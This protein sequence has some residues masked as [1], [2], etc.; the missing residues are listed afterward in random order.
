MSEKNVAIV[1]AGGIGE[2]MK[3]SVPKQ[4]INLAGKPVILHTLEPFEKSDLIS[5]IIVVCHEDSI[6][7]MDRLLKKYKISET[8]N[9]FG[10]VTQCASYT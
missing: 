4:L 3:K 5:D 2:R 9:G 1:L 7:D 8:N 10:K 6:K